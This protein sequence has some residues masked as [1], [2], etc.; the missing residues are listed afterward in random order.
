MDQMDLDPTFDSFYFP[1]GGI[2]RYILSCGN[3]PSAGNSPH[4]YAGR[5]GPFE[6][7]V[8]LGNPQY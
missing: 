6:P 3:E 7:V 2:L 1:L 5:I 4:I 8:R